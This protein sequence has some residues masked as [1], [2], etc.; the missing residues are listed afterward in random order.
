MIINMTIDYTGELDRDYLIH[1]NITTSLNKK[2][3]E[4]IDTSVK[5]KNV[6]CYAGWHH[7]V[8]PIDIHFIKD[9][10]T[11]HHRELRSLTVALPLHPSAMAD[12]NKV[13][14]SI[15]VLIIGPPTGGTQTPPTTSAPPQTTP[16]SPAEEQ[17]T[18]TQEETT[19]KTSGQTET[20]TPGETT[21]PEEKGGKGIVLAGAVLVV[22]I[23]I[24]AFYIM[25]K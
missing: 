2:F 3:K 22:I 7:N 12:P 1:F 24:L 10:K 20:K 5:T 18:G 6:N 4:L 14:N 19:R 25:R 8:T 21:Q 9:W 16:L 23:I 15:E 17:T 11:P 13:L